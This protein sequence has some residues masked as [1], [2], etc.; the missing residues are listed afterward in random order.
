VEVV[1]DRAT[2]RLTVYLLDGEAEAA[3]R[4]R[5]VEIEA[6]VERLDIDGRP[7]G[8]VPPLKLRLAPVASALTGESVGDA[9]QFVAA[10]ETLRGHARIRGVLARVEARGQA[11][12]EVA[13]DIG[14]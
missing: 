5:Q 3:L 9:S 11:F 14:P 7:L 6:R 13:F 8:G 1:F 2:G 4:S 10:H 12:D